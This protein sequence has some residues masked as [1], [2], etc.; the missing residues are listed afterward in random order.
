M[1]LANLGAFHPDSLW[2]ISSTLSALVMVFKV[3]VFF[4]HEKQ[5]IMLL[6]SGTYEDGPLNDAIPAA[7]PEMLHKL[8]FC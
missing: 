5:L 7:T 1:L 2:I 8:C 3:S 6:I 4:H